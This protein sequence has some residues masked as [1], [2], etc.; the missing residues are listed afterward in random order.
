MKYKDKFYININWLL[1]PLARRKKVLWIIEKNLYDSTYYDNRG[2][3]IAQWFHFET[4]PLTQLEL[5]L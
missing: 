4:E 3:T 1:T 5:K 2:E